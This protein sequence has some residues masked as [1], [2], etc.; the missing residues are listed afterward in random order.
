[1]L[2][3]LQK[4]VE[5]RIELSS[6]TVTYVAKP[7]NL[8]TKI[9]QRIN[10]KIFS[11]RTKYALAKYSR[12]ILLY[13]AQRVKEARNVLNPIALLIHI[14]KQCTIKPIHK[15]SDIGILSDNDRQIKTVRLTVKENNQRTNK[16]FL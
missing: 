6:T 14:C 15:N 7:E 10:T 12:D 3:N 4:R 16:Y 9:E 13:A 2:E 5:Q 8:L 11:K 1:M